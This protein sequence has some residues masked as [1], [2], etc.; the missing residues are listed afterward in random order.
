MDGAHAADDRSDA[1]TNR[2]GCTRFELRLSD[3]APKILTKVHGATREPPSSM[4]LC[5]YLSIS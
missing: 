5:P 3:S 2:E 1:L 4:G